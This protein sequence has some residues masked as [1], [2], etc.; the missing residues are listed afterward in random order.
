MPAFL[1]ILSNVSTSF[2][3]S[4]TDGFIIQQ[5]S[6]WVNPSVHSRHEGY[7]GH[8][9]VLNKVNQLIQGGLTW[10]ANGK[11]GDLLLQQF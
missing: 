11:K 4:T 9:C 7:Y 8:K 2:G 3:I 10:I 1:R 5:I 6:G